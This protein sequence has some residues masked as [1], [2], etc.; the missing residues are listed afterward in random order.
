[1]RR[2]RLVPGEDSHTDREADW[3]WDDA[4]DWDDDPRDPRAAGRT[5][6]TDRRAAARAVAARRRRLGAHNA[7]P[8]RGAAKTW[9]RRFFAVLAFA[10]LLAAL[11]L[12]NATFQ[13]FH[14][15]GEGAVSVSIPEG[16]D[17]GRIGDILADRGVVDSGFFFQLNA[18]ATFRRGELKPGDY[19]LRRGMSYS[20]A[21]EALEQGPKAKVV[22]TFDVTIPEG[23]SRREVA[24]LIR[25]SAVKGNY[26]KASG[27]PSVL[28][29]ARRLGAPAGAR[30]AEGFLFPSTYTLIA[31]ADA[32]DLVSRQLD[33]FKAN[34]SKVGMGYAR[35]RNLTR[36]DVLIIASMVEREAQLAKERPLIAAVIYN[37]LRQGIPLGIDATTRYATNNWTRPIRVSELQSDSPYNTRIRQGLPPTPIGNPGLSSLQAAAHP[38]RKP[39]L[40]FVR[41][42]GNSGAHAFSS[43]NAQFLR[44]QA[45]YQASR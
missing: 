45:R 14:G 3:D 30:T 17:A 16:V 13:P 31:G 35:T 10:A 19:Q 15:D 4:P 11:Y 43:T 18:T 2:A 1:M 41:K 36:Y 22:K 34:V 29:R 20:A 12:I 8:P 27:R 26:L 5:A 39:Y 42:P 32:K 25:R 40:F 9:G 37:R 21:I 33:A 7:P 44:D 23:P 24:P 38:A 28:R 6:V